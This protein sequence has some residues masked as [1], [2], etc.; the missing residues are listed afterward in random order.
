MRPSATW[1]VAGWCARPKR[2]P[3]FRRWRISLGRRFS[4]KPGFRWASFI[5]RGA[6]RRPSRGRGAKCWSKTPSY[7]RF[8]SA[9]RPAYET[10]LAAWKAEK[11]ANPASTSPKPAEPLGATSNKSPTKL[12]NGMIR[13]LE[14]YTLR[15]V[16]W[17]QGESNAERA[18]QCRRL[19][20]AM[21]NSW[22]TEWQQPD[23][24]FYFV[25]IAPHKSQNAEI[26]EAR[27]VTLQTVPHTGMAVTTDMGDSLDIHPRNKLIVGQRLAR[28]ALHNE[29]GERK[30]PTSGPLYEGLLVRGGKA[31]VTFDHAEA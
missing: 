20:P 1:E 31:E 15:G 4:A 26:R 10:A 22:R 17:Y 21:L 16:I 8:W 24:P 2:R 18:Y 11:A 30:L 28:W 27:L 19:F 7:G 9:T 23:L 25:Q 12:Y 14:P 6:A 13:G 5:R 29:Y 3:H